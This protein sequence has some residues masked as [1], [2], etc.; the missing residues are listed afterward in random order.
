MNE[1]AISNA[2]YV[3]WLKILFYIAVADTVLSTLNTFSILPGFFP[4]FGRVATL[5]QLAVL[6]RLS[7]LTKRYKKA[8]IFRLFALILPLGATI[9]YVS[10]VL[11]LAALVFSWLACYQE[12]R[13]HG[14]LSYEKDLN[15]A[16]WWNRLFE[17]SIILTFILGLVCVA[18]VWLIGRL[19][20]NAALQSF[21]K[22]AVF[23]I[24]SLLVSVCFYLRYLRKTIT[25]FSEEN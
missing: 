7:F 11:T 4:W 19:Q 1:T 23:A 22:N 13:G 3:K 5:L 24:P 21:L 14:E 17:L 8:G 9:R 25:V 10:L 2:I 20:M 6:L 16:D 15:L 12:Y 18:A